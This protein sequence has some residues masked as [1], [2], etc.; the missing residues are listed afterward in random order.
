MPE[1]VFSAA[2]HE[3]RLDGRVLP[4]VTQILAPL[5]D[6]GSVP[7][8]VLARAAEFGTHVH[9]AINLMLRCVLDWNS[10]DLALVPYVA[11]AQRFVEES[12]L[13]VIASEMRVYHK[14][15]HF[16]GTLD[17][18][19]DWK[20][21]RC[22][23]DWKTGAIPRSTGPQLAGYAL[24]LATAAPPVK[25]RYCVQLIPNDY[26]VTALTDPADRGIFQSC[27][28]VYHWKTKHAA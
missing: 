9:Q 21:S 2:R 18:L 7:A 15:L 11:G 6:F 19:A 1:L 10:L 8:E 23:F 27:L 5:E 28:N 14:G 12:G 17:L 20:G 22:L 13:H 26:R 4:S 24:A 25:R 3:Y 16:A